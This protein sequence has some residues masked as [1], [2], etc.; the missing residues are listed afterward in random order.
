M[1]R[2]RTGTKAISVV[3]KH[4]PWIE[5]IRVFKRHFLSEPVE[6]ALTKR[7]PF[8][9]SSWGDF[10]DEVE[11]DLEFNFR[12]ETKN[13]TEMVH[14]LTESKDA[15]ER[16]EAMKCVN[17]GLGGPF[18]KYCRADALH[19]RRLE[20]R[21]GQGTR[22]RAPDGLPQQGESDSGLRRRCSAQRGHHAGRFADAAILQIEGAP[23]GAS[24]AA[25]ERPQCSDAVCR[26]HGD[27]F[28][29]GGGHRHHFL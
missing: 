1:T 27:S 20:G 8:D 7:S 4:R 10:F 5:H 13:L 14:L 2:S 23:P 3:A 21:R 19:G 25:L 6:S 28:R 9:S 29:R 18:A 26:Y 15:E 22:L 12:G 24:A 17:D 16:A 11:A